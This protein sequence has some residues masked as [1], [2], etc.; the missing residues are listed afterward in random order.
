MCKLLL[1]L[2][3]SHITQELGTGRTYC[4][5]F[6][7]FIAR[8]NGMVWLD[9][10]EVVMLMVMVIGGVVMILKGKVTR[11]WREYVYNF[12]LKRKM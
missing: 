9:V 7:L 12:Q 10:W 1:E 8:R 11:W 3:F 5:I 4:K 2:K 6:R